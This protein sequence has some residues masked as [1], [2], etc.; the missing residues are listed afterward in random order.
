MTTKAAPKPVAA[1][2]TTPAA[3]S[4]AGA[5]SPVPA[6]SANCHCPYKQANL[7]QQ[8][9]SPN[10]M[11]VGFLLG[12]GCPVSIRVDLPG[13][14]TAPLIPDIA[15]LT[16]QIRTEIQ[17]DDKHK[18]TFAGV[19][20]RLGDAGK[21]NP[22]IEEILT[23]I[24]AL[25]DVIGNGV[26]DTLSKT[27]LTA[28]DDEICRITTEIVGAPLPPDGT[29]Y[30]Q[31]A[32][33]IGG[34]E[35]AHPVEIFTPNYDLLS[36]QALEQCRV[37]YF[38]GFVGSHSTFFD[39]ASIEQDILPPRW[40][41]IW[42]LHGSINWWRTADGNVERRGIGATN[43]AAGRQMIYPSHLKYDQSRRL[44][45]LA[46]LDR[47]KSFLARGQAV[48]ITCGYSFADQHLNEVILQ[49]LSGNPKAVCFGLLHGDRSAYSEA[50]SR[51]R[52]HPN[53]SLLA[54]DGAVLNTIERDWRV[55]AKEEHP[56]HG[57]AAQVGEMKG[58]TTAP[59]DRCKFLL[60]DFKS[61]GLFLAQ[62]LSSNEDGGETN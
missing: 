31:L 62:H 38:D 7:L 10:K 19:I 16:T 15:N 1:Q 29:P 6:S 55:G 52:K 13:G 49:G 5:A 41:R 32:A 8:A 57:I 36:E 46:M 50:L 23:H 26:I 61:M 53:L 2:P 44:P 47:L 11:R 42:K 30:H 40:S 14:G 34:I 59:A 54:A 20:A 51:A 28:L 56:W 22:N 37:P 45:Y 24:R 3:V 58:R 39:V 4:T 18:G 33:W 21:A 12:A 43:S 17:A 27:T 25:V 48:L 35:R 9:L 60:G